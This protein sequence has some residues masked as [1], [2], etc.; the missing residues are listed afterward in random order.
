[1]LNISYVIIQ[2]ELS[3][4][5]KKDILILDDDFDIVSFIRTYENTLV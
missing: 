3:R 2:V 4:P 5:R 1:M